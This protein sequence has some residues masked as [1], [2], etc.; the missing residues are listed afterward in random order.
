MKSIINY[1]NCSDLLIGNTSQ[2]SY[3]F[4]DDIV[5]ISSRN[6][7]ADIFEK[8]WNKVYL[9]FAEQRTFKNSDL[10]FEQIN[11]NYTKEIVEKLK[12]NIIIY[13]STAELWNNYNGEITI[14]TP[15]N[16]NHSDYIESKEKITKHLKQNYDNIKI[17][18]PFN[19]NSKYRLPP[20]LFGKIINSIQHKSKIQIGDTYFYRELLHPSLVVKHSIC[21][22][23]DTIIGT[24]NLIFINDFIRKLYN[25]FDMKYDDYVVEN[26]EQK[27]IYRKNIFYNKTRISFTERNLLD[28]LVEEI[29]DTI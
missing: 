25:E 13:Y 9:C 10:L 6:I 7:S 8:S 18:Y 20:F 19:F 1:E 28:I 3:Y 29:K 22:E 2:L 15:F 17:I 4:P 21:Q 24:G 26:I 12:A 27:S 23:N 16:Y 5:K 11:V 14:N